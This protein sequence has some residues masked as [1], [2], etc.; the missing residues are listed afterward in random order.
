MATSKKFSDD[1]P[2]TKKLRSLGNFTFIPAVY[3]AYDL[4]EN[5]VPAQATT[6]ALHFLSFAALALLPTL[7]LPVAAQAR[8]ARCGR[9]ASEPSPR[10]SAAYRL[11]PRQA[12]GGVRNRGH[13]GRCG[14]RRAGGM[15]APRQ[16]AMGD[17]V[18]GERRHRRLRFGR[19]QAPQ[20]RVG[21][22]MGVPVGILLGQLLPH[23]IFAY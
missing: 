9:G 11:W 12:L 14:R 1:G 17:L 7:V 22:V 8:G 10:N 5:L 6:R 3:L 13:L 16:W 2:S 19:H 4:S 21:T 20:P 18:G 23:T 15:A